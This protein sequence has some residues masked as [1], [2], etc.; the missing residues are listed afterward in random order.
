LATIH[1]HQ[2]APSALVTSPRGDL[3][4]SGCREGTVRVFGIDTKQQLRQF[5]GHGR[6]VT[7]LAIASGGRQVASVAMDNQ[8]MVWDLAAGEQVIT[9]W[10][11]GDEDFASVAMLA[12][13]ETILC[14]LSDGRLRVWTLT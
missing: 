3:V 6:T 5:D 14:G 8:L 2:S 7:S 1:G 12:D 4:V 10:G 11:E 13:G 9:L